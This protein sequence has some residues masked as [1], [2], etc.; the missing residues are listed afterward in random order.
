MLGGVIQTTVVTVKLA[1]KSA[2]ETDAAVPMSAAQGSITSSNAYWRAMSNNR[3]GMSIVAAYSA[4][5]S[6]ALSNMQ[7]G[8]I[9]D[10]VAR[11]LGWSQTSLK[12]LVMFV[13]GSTY[14]NNG[15][16]GMTYSNGGVGGRIVMPQIG[17]LTNPVVAHEFGHALGLDHANSLQCGSGA[18]DV[19]PGPYGGFAD[20]TC[21]IRTYGDNIDLMGISYYDL[22]PAISS[23]NW[24]SM[25]L[26]R[27]DEVAN[28]GTITSARSFTLQPWAGTAS[29]RAVKFT[30]SRSGEV[31]YLE[32]R[33]SVGYDS[34]VA[35]AGNRGVKIVQQGGNYSSILLPRST[36]PFS[37]NYSKTQA[38]QT[39]DTFTTHA[40]TT[41]TIDSISDASASVTVRPYGIPAMGYWEGADLSRTSDKASLTVRGWAMDGANTSASIPVH[42]YITAPNGTETPYVLTADQPRADV[43]Q[44]MQVQGNHGFSR[45]FDLSTPGTYKVCV[46]ALGSIANA[47]LGCRSISVAGVPA[48]YGYLE[49]VTAGTGAAGAQLAVT[50]WTYDAGTPAA[51]IP[52]HVYVTSPDG[53]TAARAFTADSPRPDVNSV[54]GVTGNHGYSVTMPISQRGSYKV[55]AYGLAVSGLSEGNS[56][57]G[58]K[59]L[60]AFP[61]DPPV[62]FVETVAVAVNGTNA[63]ITTSGWS[64]DPGTPD[65][66]VPVHVYI[67]A[68]DGTTT[69]AAFTAD[70]PRSDVNRIMQVPGN[71]GFTTSMS[72]SQPGTYRVCVYALAVSP[73]SRGNA[74]LDCR[75]VT[76]QA[77]PPAIG[78]LEAA[79]VQTSSQGARVVAKGWTVDP[80]VTDASIPVHTYITYPDGSTKGY[81]FTAN[82]ERPDVNRVFSITGNHGYETSVPVTQRGT[83]RV[84]TWGVGVSPLKSGNSQLGCLTIQY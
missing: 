42:V 79:S 52:V 1:D 18:Q 61:A 77:T 64:Y 80:A 22:M 9:A 17:R 35:T 84:C 5:P 4:F 82:L 44:I 28:A 53:T 21:S 20:S 36:L 29:Q 76:A 33:T 48:P 34:G 69:A 46:Y 7:P 10:I 75:S 57:L 62:G 13:P 37:G 65:R 15:A 11:E 16:A 58:C 25:G 32:L 6:S 60:D 40:G 73:V 8:Q 3:V 14:L 54:M 24:D 39:G 55:C 26:G 12:A 49:A 81:A 31:Y 83:Y 74:L 68:P 78:Y 66:S 23:P 45:T 63:A 47:G 2:A 38:W 71:H 56:L 59:T 72:I 51:S 67:T 50:G 19:A 41:V 43:N 27:G 30:D 70:Q